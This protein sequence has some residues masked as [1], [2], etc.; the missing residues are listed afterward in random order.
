MRVTY[1]AGDV[2]RLVAEALQLG[3]V[4]TLVAAGELHLAFTACCTHA[5]CLRCH[6]HAWWTGSAPH[7]C[8]VLA[9][10]FT[11]NPFPAAVHPTF[12]LP[13]TPASRPG[14]DGTVCE[15]VDALLKHTGGE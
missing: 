13:S 6:R 8:P 7:E 3:S 14:G 4:D 11:P 12:S 9:Q 5:S 10:S 2:D 15:V 1:E